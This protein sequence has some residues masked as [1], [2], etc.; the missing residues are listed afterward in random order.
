MEGVEPVIIRDDEQLDC[1]WVADR[2]ALGG[3]IWN[4]ANIRQLAKV[5]ITH[6]V[7]LQTAFDDTQ[8]AEGT[9]D[10]VLWCPFRDDPLSMN[11]MLR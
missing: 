6:V 8:I 1:S 4:R 2:F 7:D 9:G 5:G 11:H 10:S 3:V